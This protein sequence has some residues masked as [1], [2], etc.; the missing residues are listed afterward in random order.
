MSSLRKIA[1]FDSLAFRLTLSYALLSTLCLM[2]VL[3]F[4]YS[5]I[6]RQLDEELD[7]ELVH[8]VIEYESML[9]T[10][11]MAILQELL[12]HE[13]K[14]EGHD[15]AFY[16]LHTRDGNT[17]F[18]SDLSGWS[19]VGLNVEAFDSAARGER[20]FDWVSTGEREFATRVLYSPLGP[21]HVIE[22]GLLADEEG[23]VLQIYWRVFLMSSLMFVALSF[24]LGSVM[25]NRSLSGVRKVT[26]AARSI[27]AGSWGLRVPVGSRRDEVAELAD[28][29][30][31]MIHRIQ[32]LVDE[33][34]NV[35]DDIAH[36]LRTPIAR[37]RA[38]AE[39]MLEEPSA[40]RAA[41]ELAA[42][43]LDECER[44]LQLINTMLE[45]SQMQAGATPFV[46]EPIDLTEITED[47]YELFR[48]AAE[49]KGIQMHLSEGPA[50]AVQGDRHRLMRAVA[51][52]VDNA[53]KY[54][55]PGGEISI[56]CE[57]R[58]GRAVVTVK[59]TGIGIDKRDVQRVFD[60]F[61]RAD[62]SRAGS[63]HGL[64][65][66]ASRAICMAHGGTI[67]VSSEPGKGSTFELFVAAS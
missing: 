29:F 54:T 56:V 52:V 42:G 66:S 2:A 25:S 49:D 55:E 64:G 14:S 58:N 32:V 10:R 9:T 35:T 8:E 7:R 50:V 19:D 37:L 17:V 44:L 46:N 30:N 21:D 33:L 23:R 31:N 3:G 65:L 27:S 4:S 1:R 61:Y 11:G 12:D 22:L 28:A 43:V 16:R 47:V 13:S 40:P 62:R 26:E 5:I 6:E 34:G 41:H 15:R 18:Q 57:R 20:R 63:G 36:D 51:H 24:L 67:G 53:V 39:S 59:D 38:T 48:P 60:R 45:I